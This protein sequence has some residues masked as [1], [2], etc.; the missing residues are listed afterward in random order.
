MKKKGEVLKNCT[1]KL[2]TKNWNWCQTCSQC[3]IRE[4]RGNR[5]TFYFVHLGMLSNYTRNH[6]Q[7]SKYIYIYIY[8]LVR[9][10]KYKLTTCVA[11]SL[12]L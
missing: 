9:E 12:N 2:K 1:S 8:I 4:A 5:A 11:R 6:K 3:Q 7:K 10:K